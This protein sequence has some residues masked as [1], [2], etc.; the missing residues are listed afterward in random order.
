VLNRKQNAILKREQLAARAVI[1]TGDTVPFAKNPA[2]DS[3][4]VM[5]ESKVDTALEVMISTGDVAIPGLNVAAAVG[6]HWTDRMIEDSDAIFFEFCS[7][8]EDSSGNLD[9]YDFN[10]SLEG[11][12]AEMR[13]YAFSRLGQGAVKE[14]MATNKA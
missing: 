3:K 5:N 8:D 2:A 13:A 7:S 14:F 4:H 9:D 10:S 12:E 11:V 6:H 1:S